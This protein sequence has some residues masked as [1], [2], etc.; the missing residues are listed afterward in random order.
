MILDRQ[1]RRLDVSLDPLVDVGAP[2]SDV[3]ADPEAWWSFPAVLQLVHHD[4][5]TGVMLAAPQ[6]GE[7]SITRTFSYVGN[8][9]PSAPF[10]TAFELLPGWTPAGSAS[11]ANMDS[12]ARGQ[13]P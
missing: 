4:R 10:P 5:P 1:L 3:S 2:V 12:L 13:R 9:S 11:Q 7:D 8:P 6:P